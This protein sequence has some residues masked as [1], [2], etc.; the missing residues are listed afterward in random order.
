MGRPLTDLTGQRFGH[1]T[2]TERDTSAGR[3]V[4]WLCLCDCGK[5]SSTY[6]NYLLKGITRSCGHL[7]AEAKTVHGHKTRADKASPTYRSWKS[8]KWRCANTAPKDWKHYGA[9]GI[10]VCPRWASS[11]E[12]FLAD[13]GE[14]PAGKTLDRIDND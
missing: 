12:A 3:H 11:F 14:R 10:A 6:T 4:K 5:T 9:R 1:L 7:R 2:V 13:M 8:M